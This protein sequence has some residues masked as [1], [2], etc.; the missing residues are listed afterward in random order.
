MVSST[1]AKNA[2]IYSLETTSSSISST[3]ET[4]QL[5]N[6]MKLGHFLTPHTNINSKW[7]K[8]QPVR[9]ETIKLPEENPGRAS[10]DIYCSSVSFDLSLQRKETKV[11]INK[12]DLI[13]IKISQKKEATKKVVEIK[14]QPDEWKKIFAK[15]NTSKAL[16]SKISKQFRQF[17]LKTTK[18]PNYKL[19]IRSLI[20]LIGCHANKPLLA[21]NMG[22]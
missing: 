22:I 6:R 8:D 4:G 18:Q 15:N 21:P 13:K 7:I 1:T 2:G 16:I 9:Q 12:G 3:S 11:K 5:H 10:F 17:N 20:S 14:I 19:G